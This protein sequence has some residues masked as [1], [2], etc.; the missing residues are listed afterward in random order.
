MATIITINTVRSISMVKPVSILH[1][2]LQLLTQQRCTN[3]KHQIQTQILPGSNDR[4][5][6]PTSIM[7]MEEETD[8]N[9]HIDA[10]FD[11]K[12]KIILTSE[13]LLTQQ[14]QKFNQNHWKI[15]PP[16]KHQL[17]PAQKI[18]QKMSYDQWEA[19]YYKYNQTSDYYPLGPQSSLAPAAPLP[20]PSPVAPLPAPVLPPAA[21]AMAPEPPPPS[22]PVIPDPPPEFERP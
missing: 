11:E 18:V 13:R 2:I 10:I 7:I 21:P 12:A 5:P 16:W 17:T 9:R 3:L 22:E 8:T 1:T 14:E 19:L 20:I 6:F 15:A 4:S